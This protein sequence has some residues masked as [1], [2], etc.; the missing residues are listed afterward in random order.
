MLPKR[1]AVAF[2]VQR[3]SCVPSSELNPHRTRPQVMQM[4]KDVRHSDEG[5]E[6]LNK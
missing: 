5:E 3:C 6:L 1:S 2:I 4:P